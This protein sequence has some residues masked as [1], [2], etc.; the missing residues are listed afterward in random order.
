M[1]ANVERFRKDLDRLLEKGRNLDLAMVHE[2]DSAGFIKQAREQ[3]G[4]AKKVE[5]LI[6]SLP[7]FKTEYQAWYS[8]SVALLRQLLPDRLANFVALYEKPKARKSID[9][10][11]YVVQDYMQNLRVTRGGGYNVVVDASAALP[12]FRQQL[13]IL[14]AATARFESSL[15]EIRQ[16]VQADLFDDEI[17]SARELLRNG[18]LR[19]AGVIAGVVLEKHLRQVCEDRA[20]RVAKKNPGISDLNEQAP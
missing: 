12:Q 13:A 2:I 3:L 8:E 6:K 1:A 18:F 15:F 4:D 19:P 14:S 20:I 9:Y 11:N 16:L 10:E 7:D 5:V 17:D